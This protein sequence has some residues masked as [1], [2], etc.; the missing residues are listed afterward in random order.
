SYSRRPSALA[1]V[2]CNGH[3]TRRARPRPQ[4]F[5][6]LSAAAAPSQARSRPAL[7]PHGARRRQRAQPRSKP[8]R[9]VATSRAR[10]GRIHLR[11]MATQS[12][13]GRTIAVPESR[14]IEV[15]AALLERRGAHVV[16]CPLITIRDAPD[17]V[18]VLEWSR[19]L[20]AG[21]FDDLILLTGEGLMRLLSCIE[22]HEP[23][24]KPGFIAALDPVR[25]ITRGPK[26]AKAL[27]ELGL[28]PDVTAERPT[29]EGVIASL[30]T[31]D[32]R[33][34]RVGVQ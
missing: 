4:Y 8:R 30:R 5:Q 34:R 17:P 7:P 10:A 28:K 12:L 2:E 33:R 6:A 15:F 27:R 9:T 16:R 13:A 20:A 14:E 23:A 32:L 21:A 22:Q 26:P 18:P 19:R 3:A 1:N 31:L 11:P 24:L 25:K 29:T